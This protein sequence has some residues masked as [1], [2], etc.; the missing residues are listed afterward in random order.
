MRRMRDMLASLSQQL[1]FS[2]FDVTL[3]FAVIFLFFFA[4]PSL[5]QSLQEKKMEGKKKTGKLRVIK[6]RKIG[7]KE[8]EQID[9]AAPPASW[10]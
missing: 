3:Y 10:K 2:P 4:A 8:D 1:I 9:V 7:E 5:S 6:R